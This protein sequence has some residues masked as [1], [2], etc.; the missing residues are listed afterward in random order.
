MDI[1]KKR[2]RVRDRDFTVHRDAATGKVLR[3]YERKIRGAG[4]PWECL[5]NVS[6]WHHAHHP[7]PGRG[8]AF[9]AI[10]ASK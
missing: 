2:V 7:V 1:T 3:V 4:R 6:V 5:V 8:I 10:E 9:E